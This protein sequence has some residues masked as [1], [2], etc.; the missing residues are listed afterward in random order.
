MYIGTYC[1]IKR[2]HHPTQSHFIE[3]LINISFKKIDQKKKKNE[4]E[5][6]NN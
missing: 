5:N 1:T 3:T 6:N 2:E 4:E